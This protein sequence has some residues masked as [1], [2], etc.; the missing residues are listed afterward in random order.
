MS[1]PNLSPPHSASGHTALSSSNNNNLNNSNVRSKSPNIPHVRID[2]SSSMEEKFVVQSDS[3]GKSAVVLGKGTFGT[4][5]LAHEVETGNKFA[6]KKVSKEKAGTVGLRLLQREVDI[7]KRVQHPNIICLLNIF[8][9]P[10]SMYLVLDYCDKGDLKKQLKLQKNGRFTEPQVQELLRKLADAVYYLHKDGII[11]RDLKLENVLCISYN[12]L[13]S[14]QNKKDSSQKHAKLTTSESADIA[15]INSDPAESKKEEQVLDFDVKLIDFGLSVIKDGYDSMIDTWVGTPLYM[16]PEVVKKTGYSHL[17]DIWSLG[18]MFHLLISGSF[19]FY[20]EVE[21]TLYKLICA[22]KL[23]FSS[24]SNHSLPT[25]SNNSNYLSPSSSLSATVHQSSSAKFWNTVSESAKHLLGK[26]LHP[27]PTHR[28][29]AGEVLDH[30]FVSGT[31]WI[32]NLRQQ[33]NVLELMSAWANDCSGDELS[34]EETPQ[35]SGSSS[36]LSNLGSTADKVQNGNIS[37]RAFSLVVTSASAETSNAE[38]PE[39]V[40]NKVSSVSSSKKN[41]NWKSDPKINLR[42]KMSASLGGKYGRKSAGE[43]EMSTQLENRTTTRGNRLDVPTSDA[44]SR[45]HSDGKLPLKT[46]K[47]DLSPNRTIKP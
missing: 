41:S 18:V 29:S 22:A 32:G 15:D 35:T 44:R 31:D 21:E 23:K 4:V 16:A 34:N 6:V 20:S 26:M 45:N 9:T 47:K 10:R 39:N 3:P 8:E 1:G 19:P 33:S 12:S 5:C 42:G 43:T 37:T 28:Y 13:K 40:T 38:G 14:S 25:L 2:D 27:M 30:P 11:H 17:C 7:L 46:N 24:R 36:R